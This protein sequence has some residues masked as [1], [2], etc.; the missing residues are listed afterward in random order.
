MEMSITRALAESKTL[1][2]RISKKTRE[3]RPFAVTVGQKIRG[4]RGY[5]DVDTF[6][7][8]IRE[9]VESLKSLISRR[10]AI[11]KA[12]DDSNYKTKV[13]IG[14]IEMTV[15]EALNKKNCLELSEKLLV[16]LERELRLAKSDVEAAFSENQRRIQSMTDDEIKASAANGRTSKDEKENILK[17]YTDMVEASSGVELQDPGNCQEWIKKL[18]EDIENFKHEV[19]YVLSESNSTTLISVPD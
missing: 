12:I 18:Q 14:G 5:L 1:K 17:K 4:D 2:E 13:A 15:L 3:L 16:Q 9:E 8:E 7:K 11:K 10:E 19:D 6:S